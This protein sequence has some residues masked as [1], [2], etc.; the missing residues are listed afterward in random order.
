MYQ[1]YQDNERMA[2]Q[3]QDLLARERLKESGYDPRRAPRASW[4]RNLLMAPGEI[5]IVLGLVGLAD[6]TYSNRSSLVILG[7]G[8]LWTVVTG[9]VGRKK[10]G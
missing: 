3:E 4:K 9:V 2:M 1:P 10:K 6:I 8:I 7:I 5:L